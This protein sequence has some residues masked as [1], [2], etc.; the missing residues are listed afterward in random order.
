MTKEEAERRRSAKETPVAAVADGQLTA[1]NLSVI[2][3]RRALPATSINIIAPSRT[4]RD[5]YSTYP[6]SAGSPPTSP[7]TAAS[8]E[9]TMKRAH[10]QLEKTGTAMVAGGSGSSSILDVLERPTE[11]DREKRERKSSGGDSQDGDHVPERT[12]TT[13]DDSRTQTTLPVVEEVGEGVTGGSSPR[14]AAEVEAENEK[15]V[16]DDDDDDDG[17]TDGDTATDTA[18]AAA[19]DQSETSLADRLSSPSAAAGPASPPRFCASP[20]AMD[21]EKSIVPLPPPQQQQQQQQHLH[22]HHRH[23]RLHQHPLLLP[24]HHLSG[25]GMDGEVLSAASSSGPGRPET[26]GG[27]GSGGGSTGTD[28]S[29][30]P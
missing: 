21:P 27:G 19:T 7:I 9:K 15:A 26:G 4:S 29:R 30:H 3:S 25:A 20:G 13:R 5:S 6:G 18:A 16:L 23:N 10:R 8:V 11:K 14:A 28:S 17:D 22:R 1:R 24:S 12:L 2:Q